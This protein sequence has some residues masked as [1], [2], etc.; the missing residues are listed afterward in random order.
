MII[1]SVLIVLTFDHEVET[2][3]PLILSVQG[4]KETLIPTCPVT[5]QWTS[6]GQAICATMDKL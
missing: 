4:S 3:I 5:G 1:V 6:N 2:C